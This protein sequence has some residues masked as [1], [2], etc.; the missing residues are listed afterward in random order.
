MDWD[1]CAGLVHYCDYILY[2]KP[3]R[4]S[5]HVLFPLPQVQAFPI[6]TCVVCYFPSTAQL[7][8]RHNAYVNRESLE[9]RLPYRHMHTCLL[10]CRISWIDIDG[11]K[12]HKEGV[13]VLQSHLLPLFGII[14]DILC[15]CADHYYFVC[16]VLRTECFSS[17]F[18]AYKVSK[19]K[20]YVLCTHSDLVD[21]HVLGLYSLSSYATCFIPMKYHLVENIW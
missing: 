2:G 13:V 8:H 18:H 6:Y 4:H 14:A 12:Y 1:G 9:L 21:H 3:L 20:E 19:T 7:K 11:T 10:L 16:N 15:R 5:F 17:H